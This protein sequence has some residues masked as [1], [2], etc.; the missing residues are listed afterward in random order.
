MCQPAGGRALRPGSGPEGRGPP[1][2]RARRRRT[3]RGNPRTPASRRRGPRSSSS[4]RLA[5]VPSSPP[6]PRRCGRVGVRLHR[7]H[8]PAPRTHLD[9]FADARGV[10]GQQV[11]S[12]V[13][14]RP[15]YGECGWIFRCR[16]PAS[17]GAN[18]TLRPFRPRC[19]LSGRHAARRPHRASL[20]PRHGEPFRAEPASVLRK[21]IRSSRA[22]MADSCGR[23]E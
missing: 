18:V 20:A 9:Q 3:D 14:D 21:A 1:A 4:S 8:E 22:A 10:M 6:N 2:R 17:R 12:L 13:Q 15:R 5:W 23:L 11:G 16:L 7:L 19:I